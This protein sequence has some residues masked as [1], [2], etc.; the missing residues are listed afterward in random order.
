[1]GSVQQLTDSPYE[2][3]RAFEDI[4][5]KIKELISNDR[6]KPGDRLPPET[7]IARQFNVGRNTIREALRVLELSGFV[8][9]QRGGKG[10]PL[11]ADTSLNRITNLFL[12][13]VRFQDVSL[14]ELKLARCQT[15]KMIFHEAI[16]NID[17]QDITNLR[18]NI[19]RAEKKL[20]NGAVAFDENIDF[21]RL[22]AKA[23]RNY[24][25]I[26]QAEL[27]L[28]I[29][30]DFRTTPSTISLK[31]SK[32][33]AEHHKKILEAIISGKNELA[34]SLLEKELLMTGDWLGEDE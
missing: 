31:R 29:Y 18:E 3:K 5:N 2:K 20:S 1:M 16:K 32:I 19:A 17:E 24:I 11:I 10:G 22:L 27:V 8:K 15:E 28:T 25:Y 21:H 14:E 7:E 9:I 13:L 23:S 34:L 33:A 30:S 12:D 26:I 6:L 4:A